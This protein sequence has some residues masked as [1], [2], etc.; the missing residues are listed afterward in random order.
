MPLAPSMRSHRLLQ[1]I[2]A[3]QVDAFRRLRRADF[4]H[5]VDSVLDPLEADARALVSE[6]AASAMVDLSEIPALVI[7][8]D[9]HQ[10]VR[11]CA[12]YLD[13]VW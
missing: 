12:G 13:S 10:V 2:C 6:G 3:I 11:R 9:D 4:S 1:S 8:E 7:N 5:P